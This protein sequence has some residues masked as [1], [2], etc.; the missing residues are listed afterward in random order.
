[1]DAYDFK[2]NPL[3]STRHF[4]DDVDTLVDWAG[5]LSATTE[6]G[7]DSAHA[8]ALQS[9]SYTTSTTYDALDRPVTVT[10]PDSSV[11][12]H[13][14]NEGGLLQAVDVNVRGSATA[15]PYM[16]HIDYNARGQRTRIDLS[17]AGNGED[18]AVSTAYAYDKE[19]FRLVGLVTRRQ[20]DAAV[21]QRLTYTYDAAGNIVQLD[22]D[23][24][25]TLFF[26]NQ[27]VEPSHKYK[28]DD[29]YRLVSAEGRERD[30]LSQTGPAL[31]TEGSIPHP[32]DGAMG[33]TY[34]QSYVYD[35]VGNLV[36]MKHQGGTE[37]S[38]GTVRWHRYYNYAEGSNRLVS[39]RN[40]S[41][42]VSLVLY[43]DTPVY[44]DTYTHNERGA[45]TAMPHLASLVRD[46]R[47]QVRSVDLG[48][49]D[50]AVYHYDAGGQRVRK[51]VRQGAN[52]RER[53]YLGGPAAV[54][55]GLGI[56]GLRQ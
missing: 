13:T 3:S 20:S 44:S 28:Y 43:A 51:V 30:G 55:M 8:S 6:A 53:L 14:Y 1:M 29:L 32:A 46:H 42:A 40:P 36:E 39:T 41:D 21:L 5:L 22:D 34:F 35:G 25:D 26:A 47:D 18:G 10:T 19:T 24:Q 9:T 27:L 2:G 33:V 15:T 48:G 23:A 31:P 7:L 50:D 54:G 16:R 38:P 52:T 4:L 45:M 37:A 11:T 17:D 12:T 49:G 56:H